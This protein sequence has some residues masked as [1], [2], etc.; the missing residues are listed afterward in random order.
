MH[1]A[2]HERRGHN[3]DRPAQWQTPHRP[4]DADADA[5]APT[6]EPDVDLVERA[7][8]EGFRGTNDPVSFLRLAGIPLAMALPDGRKAHLLRVEEEERTDVGAV[9]ALLGGG[10]RVRPLPAKLVGRRR[11]LRFFYQADGEPPLVVDFATARAA[12]AVPPD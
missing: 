1:D 11:Q 9:T 8:I 6:T 10:H 5:G 2:D 4:P 12:S 7:F 3:A